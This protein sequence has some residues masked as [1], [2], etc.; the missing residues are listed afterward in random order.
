MRVM[1]QKFGG[2]SV[3]T[4]E[5]RALAADRVAQAVEAGWSV[6]VVVSAIGRKGAPYATD[7]LLG[8]LNGVDPQVSPAPR[9]SDLLLA[10]GEV[11]STVI[12]AQTLRARGYETIA[13]TGGQAGIITD[14]EYT[15]ARILEIQP[16]YLLQQL[17]TGRIVFVAGFQGAT[18]RGAIT[19][20]GRGGSDT[21][22]SALGAAVKPHVEH[23]EVEIYTDVDGVKTADPRIVKDARTLAVASYAEVSEMAHQGAKVVHPRAAEIA[24]IHDVPLWVKSTFEEAPGTLIRRANSSEDSSP[25]ITGVTS[26]GKLVYLRF[27][28]PDVSDTDRA[29][30]ERE[31][32][33]LLRNEE[34]SI[35]LSSTGNGAFA[36]AVVREH[37]GRVAELI[38]GLVIPGELG[39]RTHPPYGV[40]TL[41]GIGSKGRGMNAQ[42]TLLAGASSLVDIR[43]VEADLVEN[44]T[45]VS[46]IATGIDDIPGIFVKMLGVLDEQG[47]WLYQTADSEFSMSVLIRE[48]DSVRAVRTLHEA[49]HLGNAG[50]CG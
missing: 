11:I 21:T 33:R 32:Y 23:V 36:F 14:Y 5:A 16:A 22:A 3:A 18:E 17:G 4:D 38:D 19:T 27:P 24:E 6:V 9:E 8:L 29:K 44:C 1:V 15:N 47:V 42:R 34:I 31:V 45:M 7:T 20:L 49:F 12:F 30:I 37:L 39:P 48:A 13:L 28:L 10:C 41:L 35:H 2:T 40:I 26:T 25:R 50:T 43:V 46:V